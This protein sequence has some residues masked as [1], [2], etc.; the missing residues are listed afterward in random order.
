MLYLKKHRQ[1]P[2]H[3]KIFY[4]TLEKVVI[5][6]FVMLG[7]VIGWL[8]ISQDTL[9]LSSAYIVAGTA[10]AISLCCIMIL[11]KMHSLFMEI[12]EQSK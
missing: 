10:I 5:T 6:L 9:T 4:G 1:V 11:L 7:S 12:K 8:W 2:E 3:L